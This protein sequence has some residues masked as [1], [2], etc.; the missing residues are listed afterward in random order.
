MKRLAAMAVVLALSVVPAVAQR[1]GS[2]GGFTG[3]HSGGGFSHG[4]GFSGG[5][6]GFNT[7]RGPS[8][9]GGSGNFVRSAPPRYSGGFNG[10][11][12]FSARPPVIRSPLQ[13]RGPDA[14][15]LG[16]PSRF[17][18]QRM[19]YPGRG[20][21]PVSPTMPGSGQRLNSISRR[22][23][24]HSPRDG[25][26]DDNGW[27]HRGGD[28]NHRRD[29][30]R[31]RDR[32]R[33]DCGFGFYG[34]YGWAGYPYLPAWGWGYP[35]LLNDWDNYDGYDSQPAGNYAAS[36]YPEYM[37]GPHDDG[38]AGQPEPQQPDY[39]PWPYSSP[40][41]P[42]SQPAPAA[43]G[44]TSPGAEAVVTLVFKD[45]RPSEQIHNYMLT[46]RT[47]SVLDQ[48][49]RDIPVDQLD[50]VATAR[51]NR[52]AGVDFSVPAATGN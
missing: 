22:M 45:G 13:M 8:F 18:S 47:L 7:G 6:G 35:Y 20:V 27:N 3:G 31:W 49:R 2:H 23:A 46:S 4:G 37:A 16:G 19:P 52:E 43:P 11:Q 28:G 14:R 38:S 15:Q 9:H 26:H 5:H 29:H 44:E 36:Q 39:T 42:A 10:S 12:G 17:V 34:L 48:R 40:A 50:L 32:D 41:P 25:G 33:D 51:V 21:R 24:Y 30:D 1:G